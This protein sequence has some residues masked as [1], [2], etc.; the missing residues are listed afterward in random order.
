MAD[1]ILIE[2]YRNRQIELAYQGF[3]LED[4]RWF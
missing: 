2:I 3:W 4:S 1:A